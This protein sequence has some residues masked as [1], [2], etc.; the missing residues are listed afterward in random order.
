MNSLYETEDISAV[1]LSFIY[2]G[3]SY[4]LKVPGDLTEEGQPQ[5]K[6]GLLLYPTS[7]QPCT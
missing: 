1:Y 2:L 7:L 3:P 6:H 5:E 4:K